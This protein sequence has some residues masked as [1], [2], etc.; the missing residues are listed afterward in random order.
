[1]LTPV[2]K[3]QNAFEFS[4]SR[5]PKQ[6]PLTVFAVMVKYFHASLFAVQVRIVRPQ[7]NGGNKKSDLGQRFQDICRNY[8]EGTPAYLSPTWFVINLV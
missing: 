7:K 6:S 2:D 8:Y 4:I 3:L 5:L 1:M